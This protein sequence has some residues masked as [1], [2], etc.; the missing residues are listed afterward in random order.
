MR[1]PIGGDPIRTAFY[2][3]GRAENRPELLLFLS[4]SWYEGCT[5]PNLED[6]VLQAR[7]GAPALL[8]TC[9]EGAQ[10]LLITA[11]E[12]DGSWTGTF[13]HDPDVDPRDVGISLPAAARAR[14]FGVRE[15]Y[16]LRFNEYLEGYAASDSENLDPLPEGGLIELEALGDDQIRGVASLQGVTSEFVAQACPGDTSLID[17]INTTWADRICNL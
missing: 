17:T 11:Y 9:R 15:A 3:V 7:V 10:H 6:P 13:P 4:T 5:L 8:S 2:R 16:R 1:G 14:Y 12:P